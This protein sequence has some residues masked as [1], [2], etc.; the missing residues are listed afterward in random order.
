MEKEIYR[1][2]QFKYLQNAN[3]VSFK[4]LTYFQ[5]IISDDSQDFFLLS[6]ENAKVIVC[7][8]V[9]LKLDLIGIWYE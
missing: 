6:D 9:Y 2:L 1:E 7:L 8:W 4:S 3:C 5:V